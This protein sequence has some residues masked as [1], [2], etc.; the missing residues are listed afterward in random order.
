[1]ICLHIVR[2]VTKYLSLLEVK[3]FEK[4]ENGLKDYYK[5]LR[6]KG[7]YLH[8]YLCTVHYCTFN[9]SFKRNKYF[10]VADTQILISGKL[11]SSMHCVYS[12]I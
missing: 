8:V 1:M 6:N 12:V 9:P 4:H 2:A 7:D 11:Q 3:K 5:Q 10:V